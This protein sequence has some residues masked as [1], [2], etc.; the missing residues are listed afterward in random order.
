M[1][2]LQDK[3]TDLHSF[4]VGDVIVDDKIYAGSTIEILASAFY[5][6][7]KD[8][9][10]DY[11]VLYDEKS[12]YTFSSVLA[13][14]M[15]KKTFVLVPVSM[16]KENKAAIMRDLDVD[17]IYDGA[18]LE[19]LIS[20]KKDSQI[21]DFRN[22]LTNGNW[23]SENYISYILYTSGTTGVP[24]GVVMSFDAVYNTFISLKE[25]YNITST[26]V[27]IN[28][29]RWSFDLSIFDFF[30][31]FFLGTKMVC[32][33]DSKN[34]QKIHDMLVKHRVTIWNSTPQVIGM[35]MRYLDLFNKKQNKNLRL[36]LV[37]GDKFEKYNCELIQRYTDGAKIISLGGATECAI[38]SVYYDCTDGFS[39][40]YAPYGYALPNQKVELDYLDNQE[41]EIVILGKGLAEGYYKNDIKT[42]EHFKTEK[43]VRKYYTG[44]IGYF[45]SKGCLYIKGR[46]DSQVKI[47]GKRYKLDEIS[48]MFSISGTQNPV[49]L[50]NDAK[51]KI[52][53]FIKEGSLSKEE[54]E[55]IIEN[56][57]LKEILNIRDG[58]QLSEFPITRN[59]KID[60]N[61]LKGLWYGK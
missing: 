1:E 36:I 31:T 26:D 45:D 61:A 4:N 60:N 6:I 39:E 59:G 12:I 54:I 7:F 29:A 28:L 25:M 10:N 34:V 38:W 11:I 27:V 18:A 55:R 37:S 33:K 19:E 5:D 8:S 16:D 2:I 9:E 58:I 53:V 22:L 46:K 15:C 51:T 42:Y 21:V 3:L 57:L 35:Y 14:I 50:A 24:K 56:S 44:D 52:G 40:S 23:S 43:G 30:C 13:S 32:V 17:Y 47:N 48:K 20:S 41:G 49:C